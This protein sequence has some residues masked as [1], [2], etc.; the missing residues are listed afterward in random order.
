MFI[1][2]DGPVRDS[3]ALT[4][5][6]CH[7]LAELYRK[8][9]PKLACNVCKR[10]YQRVSASVIFNLIRHPK[11]NKKNQVAPIGE[12]MHRIQISTSVHTTLLW[13]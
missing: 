7:H 12:Q 8:E 5:S 2:P 4:L 13:I 10:N 6:N 3:C 1:L 11:K 9:L